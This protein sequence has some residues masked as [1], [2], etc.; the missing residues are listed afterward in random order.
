MIPDRQKF[1]KKFYEGIE[2]F[3][4]LLSIARCSDLQKDAIENLRVVRNNLSKMKAYAIKGSDED[5][6]NFLLGC[7]CLTEAIVA[8]LEMWIMLKNEDPE[9]AWDKLISAQMAS[10]D[11]IRAHEEF[12]D[13]SQY[14]ERLEVIEKFIFPPQVFLSIGMIVKHQICSICSEEYEDCPHLIGRP[15]MGEFCS[16]VATDFNIDHAG[17]VSNPADKRC[18]VIQFDV[19]G[20]VRNRMTW[21]IDKSQNYNK[22]DAENLTVSA[23]LMTLHG[24]GQ[25]LTSKIPIYAAVS[26]DKDEEHSA[27]ADDVF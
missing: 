11:A 26:S 7:L 15:Y 8:E 2:K 17:I 1:A 18:R 20:G 21:R 3:E 16:I 5:F 13:I 9:A 24:G 10:M 19:K 22:E 12:R 27:R 23:N 4:I 6:A 25:Y 14:C